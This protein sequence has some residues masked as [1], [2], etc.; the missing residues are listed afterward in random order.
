MEYFKRLSFSEYDLYSEYQRMLDEG[1]IDY[2]GGNQICLTTIPE[3][4]DDIYL[5]K[6]SLWYD[7]SRMYK[8]IDENGNEKIIVPPIDDPLDE[9]DFTY[10]CD[11]FRG[12]VFE[13]VYD[14]LSQVYELGRIRFMKMDP[15]QCFSWHKDPSP[16]IHY[17]LVT[18]EG[19]FMVIEDE[20]VHMPKHTWWWAN[21]EVPHTAVN[22]SLNDRVH[23]VFVILGEKNNEHSSPK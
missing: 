13:K 21:T 16:R 19:C 5:G 3:K 22:S 7:W 17:P 2:D 18:H 23:I 14:E 10:L 20:M 6:N 8:E 11:R 12:T 15:K 9:E 1:I 4:P